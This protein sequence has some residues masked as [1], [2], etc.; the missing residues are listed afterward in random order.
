MLWIL[1]LC[2]RLCSWMRIKTPHRLR[3]TLPRKCFLFFLSIGNC[4]RPSSPRALCVGVYQLFHLSLTFQVIIK[5]HPIKMSRRNQQLGR[6][7][8]PF[9]RRESHG[10]PFVWLGQQSRESQGIS[11]RR[12]KEG[13][14]GTNEQ[15]LMAC[16][17]SVT[18]CVVWMSQKA[19]R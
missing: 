5:K 9:R 18:I 7:R 15:T 10:D 13:R 14:R 12:L 11:C 4:D 2:V 19:I 3:R 17:T 6:I 16:N 1:V 8:F